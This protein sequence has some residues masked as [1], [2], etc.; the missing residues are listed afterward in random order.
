MGINPASGEL[1]TRTLVDHLQ[2]RCDCVRA[3]VRFK[4]PWRY[5]WRVMMMEH[6]E[7]G[8]P[9]SQHSLILGM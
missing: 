1:Q 9:A 7:M 8:S 6:L 5:I 3:C 4:V 2:E